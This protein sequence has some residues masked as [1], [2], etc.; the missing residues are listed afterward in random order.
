MRSPSRNNTLPVPGTPGAGEM[1][2]LRIPSKRSVAGASDSGSSRAPSRE[3]DKEWDG[4]PTK[5]EALLKLRHG[6]GREQ[7]YG[8]RFRM[9]SCSY[10]ME[11]TQICTCSEDKTCRIFDRLSQKQLFKFMHNEL[12]RCAAISRSNRYVC[13]GCDDQHCRMFP[14]CREEDHPEL[15]QGEEYYW[16]NHSNYLTS[17]SFG[18]E[19]RLLLTTCRD[20]TTRIWDIGN[21]ELRVP[22]VKWKMEDPVLQAA[23][24]PDQT[25]IGIASGA[26]RYFGVAAVYQMDHK[27]NTEPGA[28]PPLA[29]L[30]HPDCVTCIAFSSNHRYCGT[31][32][33][34]GEARVFDLRHFDQVASFKHPNFVRSISFTNCCR[35]I[36]T[37]CEDG[38]IRVFNIALRKTLQCFSTGEPLT[39]ATLSPCGLEVAST[40]SEGQL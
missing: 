23:F 40:S 24:S 19:D 22:M 17:I 2:T 27:G 14:L 25:K 12:V 21:M 29:F 3:K 4:D 39:W 13:V 16:L 38:C 30:E 10:N 11:G 6:T 33:L 34:D 26:Q 28:A 7:R 8:P 35:C 32:C 37:S 5:F 15:K 31:A 9:M 20:R 1:S 36:C 18:Q